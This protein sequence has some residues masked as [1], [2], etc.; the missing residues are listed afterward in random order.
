[1]R[2]KASGMPRPGKRNAERANR[3]DP[4]RKQTAALA[5]LAASV[6]GLTG[7]TVPFSLTT[8]FDGVTCDRV[9]D[10]VDL[11]TIGEVSAEVGTPPDT[12]FIT[13]IRVPE[14]V[15]S[16]VTVG[17]G[18]RLTSSAQFGLYDFA[19]YRGSTGQLIFSSPFAEDATEAATVGQVV[20]TFP[21]LAPALSCATAGSRVVAALAP[22]EV[23][24]AVAQNFG[25]AEDES[26]LVVLDVRDAFLARATGQLQFNDGHGLPSVVRAPDGRPGIVIPGVDAPSE[27]TTQ[28]LI[29]GEGEEITETGT[30]RVHYTGVTWAGKTVFDSSWDRGTP[31][32]FSLDG[33]VEG[34]REALRGQTVGSQIMVVVPP[35]LGYGDAPRGNIPAGSTL[36]FVFD[37]LG[38]DPS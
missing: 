9:G 19:L 3:L 29:K 18:V 24:E 22:D 11:A 16:D 31:A 14:S 2:P 21:G 12:R 20:E 17:D 1:M 25:I 34:V 8:S 38:N 5:V 27:L 6:L 15:Y 30:F 23:G 13:P 32:Q 36:V 26:L 10:A 7:C 35:E 4:V 37:I 33:V 28:V